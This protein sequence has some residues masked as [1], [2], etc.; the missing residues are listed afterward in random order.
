MFLIPGLQLTGVDPGLVIT[1]HGLAVFTPRWK[2]GD[3]G[4]VA[5]G[6][7]VTMMCGCPITPLPPPAG[8]EAYWPENEFLVFAQYWGD[9]G[10]AGQAGMTC[11]PNS[12]YSVTISGLTPGNTYY[13]FVVAL[14]QA[15]TNVG[16]SATVTFTA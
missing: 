8:V 1:L 3:P 15:E 11:G 7:E 12:T 4:T 13:F 5:I 16:A 6:A 9:D 10:I 14:Q 2:P